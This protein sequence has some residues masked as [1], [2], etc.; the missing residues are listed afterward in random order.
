MKAT[1]HARPG[2]AME[3]TNRTFRSF[4]SARVA[5]GIPDGELWY[6][7][8]WEVCTLYQSGVPIVRCAWAMTAQGIEVRWWRGEV[9]CA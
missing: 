6:V 9:A 4:A 2:D 1:T 5:S 8:D 7:R 3:A